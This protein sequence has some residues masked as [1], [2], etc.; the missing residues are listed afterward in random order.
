MARN[1]A[2]IPT[3]DSIIPLQ[4]L[5][6]TGNS[7]VFTLTRLTYPAEIILNYQAVLKPLLAPEEEV[8]QEAAATVE[9]A[10][11]EAEEVIL[12]PPPAA[13]LP[14]LPMSGMKST[15]STA[16]ANV[17]EKEKKIQDGILTWTGETAPLILAEATMLKLFW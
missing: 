5:L 17:W 15:L 3:T 16:M 9:A 14:I 2:V 12:S 13:P 11:A 10:L 4:T 6:K 8:T 1:A 7:I